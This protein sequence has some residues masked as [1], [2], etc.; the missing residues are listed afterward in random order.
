MYCIKNYK[1]LLTEIE[2]CNIRIEGLEAEREIYKKSIYNNAP[3]E[4]SGQTYSDA[5]WK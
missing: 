5:A 4:L 1:D 3:K 2:L